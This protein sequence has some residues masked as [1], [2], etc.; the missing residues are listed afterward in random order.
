M[1][2]FTSHCRCNTLDGAVVVCSKQTQE[3]W[4]HLTLS[5]SD[6]DGQRETEGDKEWEREKKEWKTE[7]DR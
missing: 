6:P 1:F 3:H 7:A 2:P 4:N 5:S